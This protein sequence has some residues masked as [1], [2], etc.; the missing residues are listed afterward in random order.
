M[1]WGRGWLTQTLEGPISAVSRFSQVEVYLARV[2]RD[3]E[4]WYAFA[5]VKTQRH[6]AVLR[7][8]PQMPEINSQGRGCD[9][10]ARSG[11]RSRTR[12]ASSLAWGSSFCSG[13][14][15]TARPWLDSKHYFSNDLAATVLTFSLMTR[16]TESILRGLRASAVIQLS[17]SGTFKL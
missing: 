1:G 4:D 13:S 15:A 6:S 16:T 8:F 7:T 10:R 9:S 14:E 11:F 5:T 3:L 12:T 2:F 17:S